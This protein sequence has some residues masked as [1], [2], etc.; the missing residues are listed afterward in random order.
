[1]FI[2]L[3]NENCLRQ[4]HSYRATFELPKGEWTQVRIPWSEY[5]GHGLDATENA[6]DASTLLRLGVVA[7]GKQMDVTLA[8]SSIGFFKT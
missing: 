6:F 4:F 3:K 7:I 8:L 1:L 2:S 5:K